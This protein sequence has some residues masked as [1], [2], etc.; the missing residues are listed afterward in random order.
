MDFFFKNLKKHKS[1]HISAMVRD[2]GKRTDGIYGRY[3]RTHIYCQCSQQNIFFQKI[4]KICKKKSKYFFFVFLKKFNI[5]LTSITV[6][7]R[8]KRLKFGTFLNIS[9]ISNKF[10]NLKKPIN[11]HLS[12]KR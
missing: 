9:K 3:L 4:T 8:A 1:A 11:L 2:R 10:Q 7:D 5:A 6:G 12:Q